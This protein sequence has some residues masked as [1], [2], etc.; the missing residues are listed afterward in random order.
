[1]VLSGEIRVRRKPNGFECRCERECKQQEPPTGLPARRTGAA[2]SRSKSRE[3]RLVRDPS[4]HVFFKEVTL[5]RRMGECNWRQSW[6]AGHVLH[7]G[8]HRPRAGPYT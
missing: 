5:L 4:F 1:M 3:L 8:A 2:A 6:N 7:L